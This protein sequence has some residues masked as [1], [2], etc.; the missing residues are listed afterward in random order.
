MTALGA[1]PDALAELA[2]EL[3][4][5]SRTLADISAVTV[6]GLRAGEWTG[7]DADRF[8]ADWGRRDGAML[9]RVAEACRAMVRTLERQA[10]QQ[11]RASAADS[12]PTVAAYAAGL[13][14]ALAHDRDVYTARLD[15]SVATAGAML[16]GELVVEHLHGDRARVTYSTKGGGG[17]SASIGGSAALDSGAGVSSGAS[18]S[19]S[20]LGTGEVR[21]TWDVREGDMARLVASLVVEQGGPSLLPVAIGAANAL[22]SLGE[23][24]LGAFGVDVDLGVGDA[25]GSLAV[26]TPA[27]TELLGG[28]LV[29]A[30]ALGGLP[31]GPP[32]EGGSGASA[33]AGAEGTLVVGTASEDGRRSLIAEAKGTLGAGLAASLP[34]GLGLRTPTGEPLVSKVRVEAP[35]DDD[36]DVTGLRTTVE[37]Q[38][39]GR[40]Q[41]VDATA[42]LAPGTAAGDAARIGQAFAD[43]GHGDVRGALR[44]TAVARHAPRRGRPPIGRHVRQRLGHT[45]DRGHRGLRRAGRQPHGDR[46]HH[47]RPSRVRRVVTYTNRMRV[48]DSSF[49]ATDS[50]GSTPEIQLTRTANQTSDRRSMAST[51]RSPA[52]PST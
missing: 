40:V 47:D 1:D 28:I 43:L 23:D 50:A 30:G 33:R 49:A 39:E 37:Y 17:L 35:L 41:R 3:S 9:R 51:S 16:A 34:G 52:V 12:S 26:P 29:S 27:R 7:P 15:G 24:L 48:A 31:W 18:A 44:G 10:D 42:V 45:V 14:P 4:A 20:L 38:S 11:R 32:S 22:D 21:R 5:A 36:G 46:L 6:T 25:I 19:A 8:L 13:V 2:R